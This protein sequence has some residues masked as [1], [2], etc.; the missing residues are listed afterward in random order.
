MVF[1]RVIFYGRLWSFSFGFIKVLFFINNFSEVIDYIFVKV[2]DMKFGS[3]YIIRV[4]ELGFKAI[5]LGCN[6]WLILIGWILIE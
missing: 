2:V 1:E 5:I 6:D 3:I 4:I